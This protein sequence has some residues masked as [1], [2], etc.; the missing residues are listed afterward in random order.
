MLGGKAGGAAVASTPWKMQANLGGDPAQQGGTKTSVAVGR[1]FGVGG[2]PG[3]GVGYGVFVGNGA[4]FVP[5][6]E[7]SGGTVGEDDGVE[8]GEGVVGEGA[9]ATDAPGS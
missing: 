5:I 2:S 6:A 3:V 4:T 1:T 8:L 7:R 9:N